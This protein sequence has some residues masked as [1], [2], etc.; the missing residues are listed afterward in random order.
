MYCTD[1]STLLHWQ[2]LRL[3]ALE[4]DLVHKKKH[5]DAQAAV[6][7]AMEYQARLERVRQ[8]LTEMKKAKE[9]ITISL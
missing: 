5:A 4:A 1:Y 2:T 6:H 8:R 3:E 9:Q 7:S